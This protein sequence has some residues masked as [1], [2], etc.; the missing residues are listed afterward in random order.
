MP[1][2]SE[3]SGFRTL[4]I[5][6]A[7]AGLLG[8]SK[9]S[10]VGPESAGYLATASQ[11]DCGYIQ[12]EF[13]QRVSWK[14]NVPIEFFVAKTIPTEF[15]QD[16]VEAA[17]VWN[18]SAGKTIIKVNFSALDSSEFSIGDLKNTISGF[19]EWD[20]SKSTQQAVTVV[21]YRGTLISEAD[22]KVNLKDFVYYSK[23]AQN[24]NQV[25]FGSLLVHE[26]GHGVGLK[27][28]PVKPTVMWATLSS[29]LIRTKL[30]D[31]DQKSIGCEY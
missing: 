10:Y 9:G 25:H 14:A 3:I 28:G 31:A 8:C 27:H 21:K 6:L 24:S 29:L 22:I 11:E 5:W 15:H 13:G 23:E 20:E 26:L 16:I 12:N 4:F 19:T 30:S 1:Y 7:A 2:L 18:Q 17:N